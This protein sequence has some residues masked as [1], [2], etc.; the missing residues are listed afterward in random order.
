MSQ[1][2]DL[3]YARPIYDDS[4]IAHVP[5]A[6]FKRKST[7]RQEI[8]PS[9]VS[10]V[11]YDH[12]NL[13]KVFIKTPIGLKTKPTK[14]KSYDYSS[15]IVLKVK[16]GSSAEEVGIFPGAVILTNDFKYGIARKKTA[17]VKFTNNT[18]IRMLSDSVDAL[19]DQLIVPDNRKIDI[20]T[21]EKSYQVIF[22][23]ED[24]HISGDKIDIKHISASE[25]DI[26]RELDR[27]PVA[28]PRFTISNRASGMR[29]S[30]RRKSSRRKRKSSRRNRK[31][32]RK[33][34]SRRNR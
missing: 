11:A 24:H 3:Q 7:S 16:E 23:A 34:K 1:T 21:T 30:R 10:D 4:I 18:S 22:E 9:K 31:S 2:P 12:K 27:R 33:R 29:K 6:T 32:R 25:L 26:K 8:S 17:K 14:I 28:R 19:S 5:Q 20:V 13:T 15:Y